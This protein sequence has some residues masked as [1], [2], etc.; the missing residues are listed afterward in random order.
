MNQEDR[1]PKTVTCPSFFSPPALP[2]SLIPP[3]PNNPVAPLP[4]SNIVT[5]SPNVSYLS[6]LPTRITTSTVPAPPVPTRQPTTSAPIGQ[7]NADSNA[8]RPITR[9]HF[10]DSVRPLVPSV[11]QLPSPSAACSSLQSSAVSVQPLALADTGTTG[12]YISISD[13][14]TIDNLQPAS[15][16][17]T[18]LLPNGN[19]ATSTHTATLNLPC[20][21]ITARVAHVSP[22]SIGSLLS[23]SVLCDHGYSAL[24][25][26]TT[27]TILDSSGRSVLSGT[28]S[29]SS[30]LWH[31][32]I[33]G[34]CI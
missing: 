24:Y 22:E 5:A 27:V 34:I 2:P 1:S 15:S 29:P 26:S 21:P 33:F 31:L 13:S 9:T 18:V 17:I 28:R 16:P 4:L 20:F 19:S 25:T 7:Y 32:P 8:P 6:P 3:V 11:V 12:H 23:I 30:N 14:A 10:R